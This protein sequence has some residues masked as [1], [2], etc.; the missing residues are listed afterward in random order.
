MVSDAKAYPVSARERASWLHPA[1]DQVA[2]GAVG[3]GAYMADVTETGT[4]CGLFMS[5]SEPDPPHV[6]TPVH[7]E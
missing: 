3:E 2:G 6:S 4:G 1:E 5:S 7:T